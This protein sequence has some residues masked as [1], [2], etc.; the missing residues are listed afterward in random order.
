LNPGKQ[1]LEEQLQKMGTVFCRLPGNS[2][3][4][5]GDWGVFTNPGFIIETNSLR[6]VRGCLDDAEKYQTAGKYLAGFISYESAP[7]F[8]EACKVFNNNNPPS[9]LL[10]LGVYDL[11]PIKIANIPEN[12]AFSEP[13][14][15]PEIS[16]N[17]YLA[18]V[19]R[20]KK[21]IFEG[22]IYQANYTF[23]LAG[24]PIQEPSNLFTFLLNNHPV[25]Y[26]AYVNTG[27]E[28]VISLSPELF[29][30]KIKDKL[31]SRPM[32]G[33]APR[34]LSYQED[35][36]M[37]NW[38]STDPKNRAENIMIVDMVRNDL[39]KICKPGSINTNPICQVETYKTVHQM[40]ST[41]S[42]NL[43]DKTSLFEILSA[44]F[45]AASIT[46][47]PKIRAM[48]IISEQE[49]SSRNVYTGSIGCFMP[50]KSLCLNVA[51]RTIQNDSSSSKL[52]IGGGIVADSQPEMEWQES[53]LKSNF[54]KFLYSPP[55]FKVLETI[56]WEN[57]S[58]KYL[59]EHLERAKNSQTYFFRKW[60]EVKVVEFL[61]QEEKHLAKHSRARVRFMLCANG[62]P[63]IEIYPLSEYGWKKQ[64]LK[65]KIS[66]ETTSC[67]DCFLYHK[68][69]NRKFYN[70]QF[71]EALSDGFDEV[72][73][74]NEK[75]ELTEG[76][77]SNIFI[78]K[79]GQW[80]TPSVQSGLLPGIWRDKMLKELAAKE[81]RIDKSN[82]LNADEIMLGNSVRGS[83]PA[84]IIQ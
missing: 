67:K 63:E 69:T 33:T 6:E 7:A 2:Y 47:A 78:K 27:K 60:D 64:K 20:I 32:K 68:T 38:L 28:Q 77:I 43:N 52:G 26:A 46:G 10:W 16:S 44:T 41:V 71:Q 39:G 48:E 75:G 35:R 5:Q 22:D 57:G 49:K 80:F 37:L 79:D 45:P 36:D 15:S 70:D 30:E 40:T 1:S 51:I 29:L 8:D 59:K 74:F 42:G 9:P 56:L 54:S 14:M 3:N 65:I 13:E 17:E 82:L 34:G 58:F 61:E 4:S 53:L 21:Y 62:K 83:A 50:D 31:Y 72:I 73:F 23:R 11:P 66:P 55:A 81:I 18:S 19:A 84:E 25:P 12:T 76:A 24:E